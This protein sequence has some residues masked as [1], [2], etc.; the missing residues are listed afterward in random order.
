MAKNFEGIRT[1]LVAMPADATD[2]MIDA[3]L[4]VDWDNE[5]ERATVHNI[6][7]A[8][9]A[10]LPSSPA[11]AATDTGLETV[12]KL[13]GI[14]GVM[15][16]RHIENLRPEAQAKYKDELV[17]RSQA[18]ELLATER[19]EKERWQNIA[20]ERHLTIRELITERN[21]ALEQVHTLRADNAALTAQIKE[22]E[23]RLADK[24]SFTSDDDALTVLE[25]YGHKETG[26]GII[27]VDMRSLDDMC[28][29]AVAYLC[30]EWDFVFQD[31]VEL[32]REALEAK[33]A[34]AEKDRLPEGHVIIEQADMLDAQGRVSQTVQ[35]TATGEEYERIVHVREAYGEDDNEYAR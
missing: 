18:E 34:A 2:E 15:L 14:M 27:K 30:A 29:A 35:V 10:K 1:A 26:N 21:D 9:T 5:D 22:L 8:M 20:N 16:L 19:A 23:Q 25:R 11:P 12:A 6:W 33:L 24:F 32:N 17:R 13:G 4:A 3:A 31:E 28:R 7:H